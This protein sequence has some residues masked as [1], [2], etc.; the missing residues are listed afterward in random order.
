[1][2]EDDDVGGRTGQDRQPAHLREGAVGR[3][4]VGFQDA[5]A[6]QGDAAAEG[7]CFRRRA[8]GPCVDDDVGAVAG[9]AERVRRRGREGAHE[10]LD[11][12][13][14]AVEVRADARTPV[15]VREELAG[16]DGDGLVHGQGFGQGLGAPADAAQADVEEVR[17]GEADEAHVFADGRKGLALGQ[18]RGDRLPVP[19]VSGLDEEDAV[20]SE[21]GDA[22]GGGKLRQVGDLARVEMVKLL[23]PRRVEG[24]DRRRR[25]DVDAARGAADGDHPTLKGAPAAGGR[26]HEARDA[27]GRAEQF[28]A[29]RTEGLSQVGVDGDDLAVRIEEENQVP[30]LD[31]VLVKVGQDAV[32]ADEPQVVAA[33]EDVGGTDVVVDGDLSVAGGVDGEAAT[34]EAVFAV[35][36]DNRLDAHRDAAAG[37]QALGQLLRQTVDDRPPGSV[38]EDDAL[39]AGEI[40][41][42]PG[43]V[44]DAAIVIRI[45]KALRLGNRQNR[46]KKGREKTDVHTVELARAAG[47]EPATN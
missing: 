22:P 18:R 38:V 29:A 40:D 1:M 42:T 35:V 13:E 3:P 11:R 8:E 2:G 46:R 45:G 4:D 21:G 39:L 14:T 27:Q 12:H 10:P 26:H 17:L 31:L 20:T 41:D 43:Q 30:G 16:R 5:E 28:V 19:P 25:A 33:L 32:E 47:F 15:R 7:E 37:R 24:V 6:G 44:K 9:E 34:P 36:V 23:Q